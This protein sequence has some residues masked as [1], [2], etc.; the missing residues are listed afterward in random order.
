L[1]KIV[2]G[3]YSANKDE[4]RMINTGIKYWR[5]CTKEGDHNEEREERENWSLHAN[6][7]ATRGSASPMV[8]KHFHSVYPPPFRS[9]I[10]F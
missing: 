3:N 5:K 9:Y 6:S 2:K 4:V 7:D 1:Y 8:L 10:H